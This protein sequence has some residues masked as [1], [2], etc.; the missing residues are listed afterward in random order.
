MNLESF[1]RVYRLW[2][3]GTTAFYAYTHSSLD[4]C[5]ALLVPMLP[6]IRT[7]LGLSYFQS[8][9]LLS[10]FA[11]TTGI[12]HFLGGWLGDRLNRRMLIAISLGSVGLATI[13]TG[14][15]STY[16]PLLLFLVFMGL[17]GGAYH[18][19]AVAMLSSHFAL[20]RIGKIIGLYM[21]GGS[22][23]FALGPIFGGLIADKLSWHSAYI[24]LSIPALA[25]ALLSFRKIKP[26]EFRSNNE[27]V[28]TLGG[29]DDTNVGTVHGHVSISQVLLPIAPI[30]TLA[31][32]I[33]F[34]AGSAMAFIPIYFVD[35]HNI[36]PI[37]AA[38]YVGIIRG[39][40]IVGSLSGGWLSD[41]MGRRNAIVWV[42]VITGPLLYLLINLP[43]SAFIFLVL[44]MFGMVIIMRQ[45]TVMSY[46]MSVTPPQLRSTVYGL[47]F[48]LYL[49]SMS[50]M[51]P[52]VGYFMDKFGILSVFNIIAFLSVA[53]S[54]LAPLLLISKS[55]K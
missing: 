4:L 16:Y 7:D 41:R 8:G 32:L 45:T 11:I 18:P 30:I 38:M 39:G 19:S 1:T 54:L 17:F 12:A 14:L 33:Q 6:F 28:E 23:G 9:L 3:G 15:S 51:Q 5:L 27:T 40:G 42:L 10:G 48:G 43:I 20:E 2:G 44:V 52:I 49:E 31:I 36:A 46:L 29:T 37:F 34:V 50:L 26:Q 24:I 22:I 35:K 25:A 47:Y 13:A 55:R 21:M 53:L